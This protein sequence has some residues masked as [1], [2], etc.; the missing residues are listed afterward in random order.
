MFTPVGKVVKPGI[1][2]LTEFAAVG[3]RMTDAAHPRIK[4]A[5]MPFSFWD[6]V[7]RKFPSKWE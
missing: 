1:A 6:V 4:H 3:V 2:V 5:R 7:L